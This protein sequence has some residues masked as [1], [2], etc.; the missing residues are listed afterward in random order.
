[1]RAAF[2]GHADQLAE[3][4]QNGVLPVHLLSLCNR[5]LIAMQIKKTPRM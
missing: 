3:Q 4:A 5:I 1:V 2:L